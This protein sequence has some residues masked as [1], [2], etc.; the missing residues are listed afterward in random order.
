MMSKTCI[1][2]KSI[3]IILEVKDTSHKQYLLLSNIYTKK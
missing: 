2:K 3:D 1:T